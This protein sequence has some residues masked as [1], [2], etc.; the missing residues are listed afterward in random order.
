MRGLTQEEHGCGI[1]IQ[2]RIRAPAGV[3]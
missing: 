3:S 1:M 2:T